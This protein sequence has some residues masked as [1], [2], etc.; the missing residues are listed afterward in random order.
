[1]NR[2]RPFLLLFIDSDTLSVQR[3]CHPLKLMT[4]LN[5]VRKKSAEEKWGRFL[6]E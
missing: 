5:R 4:F 3:K 6:S 1:M 2:A